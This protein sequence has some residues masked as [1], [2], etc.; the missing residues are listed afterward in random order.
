MPRPGAAPGH[1]TSRGFAGGIQWHHHTPA[2]AGRRLAEKLLFFSSGHPTPVSA[3]AKCFQLSEVNLLSPPLCPGLSR[4]GTAT[5]P[6]P[7]MPLL[8]SPALSSHPV[9]TAEE[10]PAQFSLL[11]GP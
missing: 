8:P 11:S 1:C 5:I 4:G 2:C 3:M 10:C 7:A 9:S 6:A